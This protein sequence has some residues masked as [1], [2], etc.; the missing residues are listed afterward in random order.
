MNKY[1]LIITLFLLS[2]LSYAG[3][4]SYIYQKL[5]RDF[6]EN[7]YF[8]NENINLGRDNQMSP[9]VKEY[10]DGY[11]FQNSRPLTESQIQNIPEANFLSY[12]IFEKAY[13]GYL[14]IKAKGLVKKEI[15]TVVDYTKSNRERRL[16]VFDMRKSKVLFNSWTQHGM[17]S[18]Q[19]DSGMAYEFS[20]I[21]RSDQTSLG[22]MLTANTYNGMWG[23]SMRLKGID[24]ELNSNVFKRAIVMHGSGMITAETVS[25]GSIGLS[26]GCITLPLYESGKFYGLSDRSLNE[27]IINTIKDGSIIFSYA[28]NMKSKWY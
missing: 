15:L 23:F 3:D 12:E 25:Y 28:E 24:P 11:E 18:D 22:F 14:K 21:P 20:N 17:G 13:A 4:A 9:F 6:Y 10:S 19:S 2:S 27:L 1:I 8:H 16:F 7:P 5:E 26:Q